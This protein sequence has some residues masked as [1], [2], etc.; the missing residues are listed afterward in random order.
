LRTALTGFYP[1]SFRASEP[2]TE[3][4]TSILKIGQ[5]L[6]T[7]LAHSGLGGVDLTSY[8]DSSES[9]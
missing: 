1:W 8:V 2:T 3:L 4:P 9:T 5:H 6:P 7:S